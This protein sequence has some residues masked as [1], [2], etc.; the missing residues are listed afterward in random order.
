MSGAWAGPDLL[1]KILGR[2]HQHM[3]HDILPLLY[4]IDGSLRTCFFATG[5]QH[6]RTFPI[7]AAQMGSA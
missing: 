6:N 2:G 7:E 4:F 5:I 3:R 1:L